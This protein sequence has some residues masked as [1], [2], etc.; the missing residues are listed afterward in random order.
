MAPNENVG[1]LDTGLG[2][3]ASREG[4]IIDTVAQTVSHV[5]SPPVVAV[6]G[7]FMAAGMDGRPTAWLAAAIFTAL[8]VLVPMA[9]LLQQWRRGEVSDIEITRRDQRQRPMLLTATCVGAAAIALQLTGAPPVV[10][11]LASILGVQSLVLLAITLS[12]KIS[13]HCTAAATFGGLLAVATG[14]ALVALAPVLLVA[15]SRL[16]LR[17]HTP[18]QCLGGSILGL[19]LMAVLWP[20]LAG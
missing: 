3:A 11:G 4:R 7:V 8:G 12:W 16:R 14:T 13:V 5:V 17:R 20:L 6:A 15:W 2:L 10:T 19:S 18:L 1:T 9:T